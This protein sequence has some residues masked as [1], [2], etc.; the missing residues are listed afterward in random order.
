MLSLLFSFFLSPISLAVPK[1]QTGRFL[2]GPENVDAHPQGCSVYKVCDLVVRSF[3]LFLLFLY[4][5]FTCCFINRAMFGN[6]RMNFM[7]I[8]Q[9][10]PP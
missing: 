6:G 3:F 10:Q 8:T 9:E 5:I 1:P 4:L 2:S 7:T